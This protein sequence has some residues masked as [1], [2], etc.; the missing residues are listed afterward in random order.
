MGRRALH[1]INARQSVVGRLPRRTLTAEKLLRSVAKLH[2]SNINLLVHSPR[3]YTCLS[4][5]DG[6]V[7]GQ[8]PFCEY[9]RLPNE[10][11]AIVSLQSCTWRR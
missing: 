10:Y 11:S 4:V 6:A 5:Y 2:R 7:S 3:W 1:C 9:P 8:T